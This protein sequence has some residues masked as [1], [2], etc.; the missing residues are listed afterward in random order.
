VGALKKSNSDLTENKAGT[1]S[2]AELKTLSSVVFAE[3]A[4]H[5]V[6]HTADDGEG[7]WL[8]SY[9]DL[10]TLLVGF[11]AMLLSFSKL[12]PEVFEQV[13]RETSKLFGGEYQVPFEQMKESLKKA[14]MGQGLGDQVLVEPK[15]SGLT[16][17]FRGAL[18]F[19]SASI[20][21]SEKAKSLLQQIAPI[22]ASEARDYQILIEGHTDDVP[23]SQGLIASNWELSSLRASSVLRFFLD[24]GFDPKN[25]RAIGL[26][27]THPVLPNR[28]ETS[29]VP[30]PENQSQNRRVVIKILPKFE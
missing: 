25:L 7:I 27:D 21:M 10:M 30:L 16:I 26:A 4:D 5:E 14:V 20:V 11:F 13:K 6:G 15:G 28:E 3:A 12:D 23:I 22:I 2:D 24:F 19:D 1:E 29:G 18:F 17:T 8:V 9:A